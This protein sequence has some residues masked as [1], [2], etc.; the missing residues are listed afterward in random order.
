V[1]ADHQLSVPVFGPFCR[2]E[3]PKGQDAETVV[4]QALSGEIWGEAPR[5]GVRPTVQAYARLL[6]AGERGIE[7]WAFQAPDTLSGPRPAWRTPGPHL[8]IESEDGREV[9]KLRVAFVRISQDLLHA[10][11]AF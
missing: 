2:L 8:A 10:S 5:T 6:R 4:L 3:A 7:F 1:A 9:A 11:A